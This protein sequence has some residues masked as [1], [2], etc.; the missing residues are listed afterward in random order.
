MLT[1]GMLFSLNLIKNSIYNKTADQQCSATNAVDNFIC[2][3]S[4]VNLGVL[5]KSEN[6]ISDIQDI[7]KFCHAYVPKNADGSLKHIPVSGN[8]FLELRCVCPLDIIISV[9]SK[10]LLIINK[11]QTSAKVIV[12]CLDDTVLECTYESCV[13]S[14]L[15]I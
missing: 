6:N 5:L 10:A 15:G 11:L 1:R 2:L 12:L 13:K 4:Q 7:L 14:L 3:V 9:N 8:I